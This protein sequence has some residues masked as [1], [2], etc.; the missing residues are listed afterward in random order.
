MK[1]QT[2]KERDYLE[3]TSQVK[4]AVEKSTLKDGVVLVRSMHTTAAITINENVDDFVPKDL[5]E[6]LEKIAPTRSDYRHNTYL[7]FSGAGTD[8]G[9]AHVHASLIGS[10]TI[11]PLEN[12]EVKMG[13]FEGIYFLEFSGPRERKVMVQILGE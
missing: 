2:Q 12:G 6:Y 9:A 11:L 10:G 13:D 7:R 5:L 8:T 1:I 4:E 3:I